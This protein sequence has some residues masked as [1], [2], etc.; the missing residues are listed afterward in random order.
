MMSDLI[1]HDEF[2]RFDCSSIR[3]GI[4]AGAPCQV[5]LCKRLVNE[6]FMKNLQVCYGTTETSPVSFMSILDDDPF[7]RIKNVG[8]ILDHLEAAIIDEHGLIVPHGIRG[9][10]MVRGYSV[11]RGYWQ[12]E[13]TR[14]I[15]A[16][17]WYHTGYVLIDAVS[18]VVFSD[19]GI[20]HANGTI[21]IVGRLK[22]MIVV[23]IYFLGGRISL[24]FG[25]LQPSQL[26]LLNV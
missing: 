9:E 7:E 14:E 4:I 22:D 11:M 18:L 17:R 23:N 20:M 8:H 3:S 10:V 6:F 16:D 2:Q 25:F 15:T 24:S 5:D 21:S 1:N 26:V 13:Q 12:V 19:I